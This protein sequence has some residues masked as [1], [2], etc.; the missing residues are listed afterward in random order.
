MV[1]IVFSDIELENGRLKVE[2]AFVNP[3][4]EFFIK[5]DKFIIKINRTYYPLQVSSHIFD[6]YKD[7]KSFSLKRITTTDNSR[8]YEVGYF[9][10]DNAVISANEFIFTGED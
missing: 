7:W 4:L 10:M 2:K 9:T 3:S 6:F 1:V 8:L 5:D